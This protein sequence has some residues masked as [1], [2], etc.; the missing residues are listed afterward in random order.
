MSGRSLEVQFARSCW[1]G[2]TEGLPQFP[3]GTFFVIF[4]FV[5]N[6]ADLPEDPVPVTAGAVLMLIGMIIAALGVLAAWRWPL[7]GGVTILLGYA[8]FEA[9]ELA[10]DS[11][12]VGGLFLVLP[13]VAL[14]HMVYGWSRR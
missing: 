10:E 2:N 14:I 8:L 3:I 1:P 7:P 6:F 9:V 12:I 4:V 11:D 13:A 5:M